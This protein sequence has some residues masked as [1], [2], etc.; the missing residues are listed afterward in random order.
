[1]SVYVNVCLEDGHGDELG[2]GLST[3]TKVD[4]LTQI[5]F[6]LA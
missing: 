6:L 4:S 5:S 1:M 2:I 3:S